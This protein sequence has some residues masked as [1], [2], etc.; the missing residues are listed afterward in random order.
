MEITIVVD[1][2]EVKLSAEQVREIWG[3]QEYEYNK[4]DALI[5]AKAYGY[6]LTPEEVEEVADLYQ[7]MQDMTI[8]DE[9]VYL[10]A[11]DEVRSQGV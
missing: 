7:E 10:R 5:H 2:K 3:A 8:P 6:E 11:I 4:E 9:Q 1:G